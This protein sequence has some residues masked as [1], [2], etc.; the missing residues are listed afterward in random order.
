MICELI[1]DN[2]RDLIWAFVVLVLGLVVVPLILSYRRYKLKVLTEA[3]KHYRK[4]SK[5]GKLIQEGVDRSIWDFSW[6]PALSA[7]LQRSKKGPLILVVFAFM[8]FV[9]LY[10]FTRDVVLGTLLSINLGVAAGMF[11][12]RDV[13]K[14]ESEP[15][16][17][18][19]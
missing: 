6:C 13:K 2:A 17:G 3:D 8:A 15:P 12:E 14:Q 19:A 18:A 5:E 1:E 9:L 10:V 16:Q 4:Y 7:L 11:V